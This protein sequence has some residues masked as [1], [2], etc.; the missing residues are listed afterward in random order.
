MRSGE[1]RSPE[2]PA[3]PLSGAADSARTTG[4]ALGLLAVAAFSITLPA[5]RVAVA[6]LDPVFVGL[7]RALVAAVLAGA[8]LALTRP[9]LPTRGE[10]RR[11]AVAS[12]G[13]VFGF[14]LFSALA[15]RS[16]PA[17][18]GAIL[19]GLLPLATA[20]AAAGLVRERPSRG[21]WIVALAGSA[22]VVAFGLIRGGGSLHVG[23]AYLLAAVAAG[24]VGYAEGA[25]LSITMGGWQVISWVLVI[26][27][28]FLLVPVGWSVAQ[29][30]L[31]ASWP[32]WL[33]FAYVSLVSQYLAFFAW[34]RGLAL[35][36][37][38]RVGQLQLL[39]PFLTLVFAALFVGEHLDWMTVAFAV[40][41]V[42]C[43]AAGR[44]MPVR[45]EG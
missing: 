10:L 43:V 38:A 15:M 28:P 14:P 9:R 8:A 42:A 31:A 24:G 2:L 26:S 45:R 12:L 22:L 1:A 5:T 6:E 4:F 44:K 17:S 20:A 11:L 39:Q 16:V 35:G 23:D 41:V 37:I 7:G 36:G 32:A 3:T 27:A 29:H 30:G 33:A 21:F 18:H 34:Y 19:I 40:A 25:R 13:V